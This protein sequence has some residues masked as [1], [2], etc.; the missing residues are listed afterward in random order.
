MRK[1]S[2]ENGWLFLMVFAITFSFQGMAQN[3]V[4]IT[5]D[6]IGPREH[7]PYWGQQYEQVV[8]YD[9]YGNPIPGT[10]TTQSVYSGKFGIPN[11]ERGMQVR[12]G[13]FDIYANSISPF[14]EN[15]N[16]DVSKGIEPL[17]DYM[18]Y[19]CRDGITM[20]EVEQYLRFNEDQLEAQSTIPQSQIDD[21]VDL[22]AHDLHDLGLKANFIMNSDFRFTPSIDNDDIPFG[23]QYDFSEISPTSSK[24][25]GLYNYLDVMSNFYSTISPYVAVTQAGWIKAPYDFNTYR[26]SGKWLRFRTPNRG[27][28][29]SSYAEQMGG[30]HVYSSNYHG[31]DRE[32]TQRFDWNV[33]HAFSFA[34]NANT[35]DFSAVRKTVLDKLLDAFPHQKI[36]TNSLTPWTNYILASYGINNTGGGNNF[37]PRQYI[38]KHFLGPFSDT[39]T[40]TSSPNYFAPDKPLLTDMFADEKYLRVGYYD[41]AFIGDSYEH[42]WTISDARANP[43]EWLNGYGNL[44]ESGDPS[45]NPSTFGSDFSNQPCYHDSY[46]TRYYRSNLWMHAD[47]P[48][49]QTGIDGDL[50]GSNQ[51]TYIDGLIDDATFN[52]NFRNENNYFTSNVYPWDVAE[53]G[54]SGTFQSGLGSALKLRYFNFTSL[55]IGHNNLLDGRSPYEM[56][57]NYS[58]DP[59]L[60]AYSNPFLHEDYNSTGTTNYINT[61]ISGW[62]SSLPS[63]LLTESVLQQY[64]MP[65]SHNY[66][67]GVMGRTYYDYIRD[68]L[69]YRLE[70]QRATLVPFN[71]SHYIVDVVMINRGFAAPQNKRPIYYV[72]LN[73]N[74]NIIQTFEVPMNLSD[75]DWR[76]WQPDEFAKSHSN[77]IGSNYNVNTP[78]NTSINSAPFNGDIDNAVIGGIPLGADSDWYQSPLN[79]P[80]QPEEYLIHSG[81]ITIPSQYFDGKHKVG[82]WMPD[83]SEE[84][85]YDPKYA[86]KFANQARYIHCNGVTVLFTLNTDND[87]NSTSVDSDYDGIPNASEDADEVYNPSE[88]KDSPILKAVDCVECEHKKYLQFDQEEEPG[89]GSSN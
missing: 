71:N 56:P 76:D 73:E 7:S 50:P 60:Q 39:Y 69:G 48:T 88:I 19:F 38:H 31:D 61:S 9:S 53:N 80:Y 84:L 74:D 36:L 41:G 83:P 55:G 85:K 49:Y 22:F 5:F 63:N 68:H 82:I 25:E 79:T 45:Y 23:N 21:A 27:A 11:P 65:I 18:K 30:T 77:S 67:K 16:G 43:V 32:S 2:T 13:V 70:M 81:D 29:Y 58:G 40:S 37:Y 52:Y 14:F 24:V 42:G 62:K 78:N 54:C 57:H 33:A 28:V 34:G 72:I 86:V 17:S 47:L 26:L 64:G 20:V 75:N 4:Q 3:W 59:D 6:G 1:I 66:F 44:Y 51:Y 87:P 35:S 15:V 12:A 8:E 10:E 89:E 46:L